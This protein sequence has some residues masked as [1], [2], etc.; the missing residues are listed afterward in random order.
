MKKTAFLTKG[1]PAL[2]IWM[3]FLNYGPIPKNKNGK[4]RTR[5]QML[6]KTIMCK[7]REMPEYYVGMSCLTIYNSYKVRKWDMRTVLKRIKEQN[8]IATTVFQRSI[9]SMKMEWICHNFLYEIG[10]VRERTK[11]VDLDNP[12]DHPEWQYIICGF[13]VWLFVW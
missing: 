4:R 6:N 9:F 11:D 2:A 1:L 12:P 10:Y 8:T 13:L 5:F 3:R 7:L